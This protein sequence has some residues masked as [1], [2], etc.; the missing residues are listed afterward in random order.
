[1]AE[2]PLL[3][4]RR[5]QDLYAL[6]LR[7]REM[8]RKDRASFKLAREALLAAT[9]IHLESGD[10]L[11]GAPGD[12]TAEWLSST[13]RISTKKK[14]SESQT[15]SGKTPAIPEDV[16]LAVCAGIAQ[17]LKAAGTKGA[18]IV[19]ASAGDK[20][21]NWAGALEYAQNSRSPLV[22]VCAD[23]SDGKRAR[24]G[25]LSW[26]EMVK[27]CKRLRLPTLSV[28]GEDAV[29]MYRVMQESLVRT[30]GGDGPV[31][32]WATLSASRGPARDSP[33]AK[34]DRYLAARGLHLTQKTARLRG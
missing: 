18:V 5:L 12:A 32:I 24:Y 16:R 7:C 28:D 19:L 6:M 3:P 4:H 21:S 34:M 27:L 23:A 22:L 11:C 14:T 30:R 29:A 26:P 15:Q 2:N 33:L 17:G 31:I 25:A 9:A 1:M 13:S 20:N 10:V 8:E